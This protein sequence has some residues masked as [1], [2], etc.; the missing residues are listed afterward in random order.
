MA[1][2][3]SKNRQQRLRRVSRRR[4]VEDVAIGTA[5]LAAVT[6][7][8]GC[9]GSASSQPIGTR[10]F[11]QPSRFEW[12][13]RE[14]HPR[15]DR[16]WAAANYSPTSPGVPGSISFL[17][18]TIGEADFAAVLLDSATEA[19]VVYAFWDGSFVQQRETVASLGVLADLLGVT[20]PNNEF[21]VARSLP[22]QDIFDG[23]SERIAEEVDDPSY[24]YRVTFPL[25]VALESGFVVFDLDTELRYYAFAVEGYGA[26]SFVKYFRSLSAVDEY[27][28]PADT[29]LD[30]YLVDNIP[31]S[32]FLDLAT[33]ARV[34]ALPAWG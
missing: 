9:S 15:A 17:G 34:E 32:D 25:D 8:V 30:D 23:A 4:F 19:D 27:E 14:V 11:Q 26:R 6:T 31:V 24:H 10:G 22:R 2:E 33:D 18:E 16:G 13:R 29:A 1:R 21:V 20:L 7:A 12:K 5:G 28:G 3:D